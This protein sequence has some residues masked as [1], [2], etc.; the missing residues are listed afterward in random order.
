MRPTEQLFRFAHP[1][2]FW[3]QYDEKM[4]CRCQT[5]LRVSA[6][7]A[8]AIVEEREA[9]AIKAEEWTLHPCQSHD[10]NPCCHART[11]A[12]IAAAIRARTP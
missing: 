2:Q 5:C 11:G 4:A 7:M 6:L 12:A 3:E 10:D 8:A 1:V 9:C